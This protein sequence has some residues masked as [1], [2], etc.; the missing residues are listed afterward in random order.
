MKLQKA[1]QQ[2]FN[3]FGDSVLKEKRLANLLSDFMAFE[4]YPAMQ[5]VMKTLVSEGYG[6]K[7]YKQNLDESDSDYLLFA[8]G[9]KKQLV[10][11]MRFKK[12]FVNYA[13]DSISFALGKKVSVLEPFDDGF[14]PYRK[15][16]NVEL[17]S[18]EQRLHSYKQ[19]YSDAVE[20]L[21]TLPEDI[22]HETAGYFTV[23]ALN[24]LYGLQLKIQI[25]QN[26]LNINDDGWCSAILQDKIDSKKREKIDAVKIALE[27]E[28]KKYEQSLQQCIVL[29]E[30]SYIHKSGHLSDEASSILD[31]IEAEIK[32]LYKELNIKYDDYC[33]KLLDT[34]LAKYVVTPRQRKIQITKKIIAP[35]II[36]LLG[37]FTGTSY[38]SSKSQI[39][40]F[41]ATI[42]K[43]DN[44]LSQGD[45]G[46]AMG[47]YQKAK[48]NYDGTFL[49]IKY[50]GE[51]EE[52]IQD[53]F[54]MIS[55]QC[56]QLI[57]EKEL[58]KANEL[59]KSIPPV[60][61]NSNE[62]I[63]NGVKL[64]NDQLNKSVDAA[65]DDLIKNIYVNGGSLNQEEKVLLEQLLQ[66]K[67]NDYWLNFI[68]NKLK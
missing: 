2:I 23:D 48:D 32:F 22:V 17:E 50:E 19:E 38:L 57:A 55:E 20:Q 4:D 16:N 67:P 21:I 13:V 46:N 34:T 30:K 47:L 9:V 6:E 62:D 18:L 66:I 40:N 37:F 41:Y 15:K 24:K 58:G 59:I 52:K 33:K 63:S 36:A 53:N 42:E 56:K 45:I 49:S 61:L 65:L 28:K 25:L 64:L 7:L 60:V 44:A 51:A 5:Q 10:N 29:P 27:E 54:K 12:E 26:E 3:Q 14:D 1:L 31:P 68:N 11:K 35:G 43:A 39:D 8:D